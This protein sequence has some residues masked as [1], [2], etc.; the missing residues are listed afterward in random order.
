MVHHQN[1][2][3]SISRPS[4][5]LNKRISTKQQEINTMK[6]TR[7]KLF[8]TIPEFPTR[9]IHSLNTSTFM[10]SVECP[11]C[12]YKRPPVKL[13]F[14]CHAVRNDTGRPDCWKSVC[15][16]CARVVTGLSPATDKPRPLHVKCP[17]CPTTCER[18]PNA[19][20]AYELILPWIASIDA[21][22]AEEDV[23]FRAFSGFPLNP[24]CCPECE[25]TFAGL[26]DLHHHMRGDDGF[27]PCPMSKIQCRTCSTFTIRSTLS[28][29]HQCISCSTSIHGPQSAR[30][31][32]TNQEWNRPAP[33]SNHIPW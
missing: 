12:L 26:S 7:G 25:N 6:V 21:I 30:E 11:I 2:V 32:N 14:P 5:N 8:D 23:V 3:L 28:S 15:I 19:G 18:F 1:S 20:L 17:W 24:I 29:S 13:K 10:K 27:A 33:V 22:L 4:D 31:Q 16:T 9:I